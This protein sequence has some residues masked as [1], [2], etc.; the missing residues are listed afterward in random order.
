MIKKI[1]ITGTSSGLGFEMANS[2]IKEYSVIGL[3]KTLGKAKK[4][5]KKNFKFISIDLSNFSDLTKLD[6]I[7]DVDCLINNASLFSIKSFDKMKQDEIIK[8]TNVNF[9]G[10]ILLTKKIMENNKKLKKI[11][12][13][14][15]VSGLHGIKNQSIYSATKHGLKGFFDSLSQE[16]IKK[17][18]ISNIFPGGMKTELW[19]S[20]DQIDKKKFSKF[21]D[22]KS[23]YR[24]VKFILT[25]EKN[26][27]IKNVTI[28]PE[29]DW[30]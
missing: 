4:I 3:S 24:L 14:L 20:I 10:T 15:S 18:S 8:I 30:H 11:I 1:I 6:K 12:N 22:T 13:I 27:I 28:F 17:V 16:N 23:V 7:K 21:L 5:K 25:Q 19:K 2:L 26:V 29:N 9:L